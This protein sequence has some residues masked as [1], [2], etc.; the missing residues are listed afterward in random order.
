M[1]LKIQSTKQNLILI[2]R[3][4]VCTGDRIGSDITGPT[5]MFMDI[6]VQG[7]Y[8]WKHDHHLI[9]VRDER[10]WAYIPPFSCTY[11]VP[12]KG[13]HLKCFGYISRQKVPT[14]IS[15]PVICRNVS[16]NLPLTYEEIVDFF[17][18]EQNF[19]NVSACSSPSS[20]AQKIKHQ[21]DQ[22]FQTGI[23]MTQISRKLRSSPA[24][25]SREFKKC[26]GYTPSYYKK[27]LRSTVGAHA[28]LS[29]VP[30]VEAASIAGFA[31]L[32]RFYKQF[33]EYL[34]STPGDLLVKKRQD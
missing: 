31:D 6:Q 17:Q 15:Y 24:V 4:Q 30:P 29:G 32:S 28:L 20:T 1:K 11:E 3:D 21:I 23:T 10:V 19:E 14:S 8:Q 34:K 18:Q 13:T 26:Y 16:G 12:A 22:N 5:W 27:G 2:G 25:L 7:S 33:K 9:Q